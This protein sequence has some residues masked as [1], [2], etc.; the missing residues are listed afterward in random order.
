MV[1]RTQTDYALRA[2]VYL[3]HISD[4]A[5]VETIASAY[6]ISKDHLVKVVQQLVRLG[7]VISRSGRN[8]GIRLAR[9]PGMINCG[10]VVA[11]FEGRHG[12]LPCVMDTN[13][14]VLEP[15]CVLRSALI[16]AEEAMYGIL[17]RLSLADVIKANHERGSGGIYNL[18]IRGRTPKVQVTVAESA[19]HAQPKAAN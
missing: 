6:G 4:Q 16:K 7:Y 5:S 11:Q 15:G 1:L 2:L 3:A 10:T 8:G 17:D 14:C 13:Y 12:L 18:T 9:E 19:A